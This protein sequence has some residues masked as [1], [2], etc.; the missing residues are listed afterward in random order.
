MYLVVEES[1]QLPPVEMVNGEC[2][3]ADEV[4]VVDGERIQLAP[5]AGKEDNSSLHG[6]PATELGL[7]CPTM[8]F[9][10]IWYWPPSVLGRTQRAQSAST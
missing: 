3:I 8:N 2:Y 5:A 6:L 4:I 9:G 10:S 1:N 7:N